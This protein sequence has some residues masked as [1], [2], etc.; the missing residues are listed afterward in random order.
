M[1]FA[2]HTRIAPAPIVQKV[3]NAIHWKI[4]YPVNNAIGLANAYTQD[5]DLSGG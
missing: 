3:D 4:H 2:R 1:T 5:S